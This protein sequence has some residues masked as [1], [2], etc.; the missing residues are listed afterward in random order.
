MPF[1]VIALITDAQSTPD[2]ASRELPTAANAV[3]GMLELVA[4]LGTGA[5]DDDAVPACPPLA[6]G[7]S[8]EYPP[9]APATTQL[10]KTFILLYFL[11]SSANLFCL[12]RSDVRWISSWIL[13]I[14]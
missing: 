11:A 9:S 13:R 7:V 1:V 8:C 6:F 4:V 14:R 3:L 12:I 2:P 10:E 5:D